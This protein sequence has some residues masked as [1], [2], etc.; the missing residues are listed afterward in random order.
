MSIRARVASPEHSNDDY[1]PLEEEPKS[2]DELHS[3]V[4]VWAAE[5]ENPSFN[6]LNTLVRSVSISLACFCL[7][8]G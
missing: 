6:V 2:V 1:E 5:H 4:E 7:L 8:F 3:L